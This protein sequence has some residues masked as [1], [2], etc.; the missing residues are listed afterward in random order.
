M[1][2]QAQVSVLLLLGRLSGH[3]YLTGHVKSSQCFESFDLIR[4]LP[5]PQDPVWVTMETLSRCRAESWC[6]ITPHLHGWWADTVSHKGCLYCLASMMADNL[7]P[8][9]SARLGS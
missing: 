5:L 4:S 9:L 8:C 7:S 2:P 1:L 3:F 6:V